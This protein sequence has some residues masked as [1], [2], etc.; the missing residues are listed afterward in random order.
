MD[1]NGRKYEVVISPQAADEKLF[2]LFV[3]DKNEN[4]LNI[5]FANAKEV[6]ESVLINIGANVSI[7]AKKMQLFLSELI[8]EMIDYEEIY[9]NGLGLAAPASNTERNKEDD[10]N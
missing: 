1:E 10:D 3:F 4:E 7:P 6:D 9:R 2:E 5:Q 8:Q